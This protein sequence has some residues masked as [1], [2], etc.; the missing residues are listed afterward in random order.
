MLNA[1]SDFGGFFVKASVFLFKFRS[2]LPRGLNGI[3]S[4]D[5]TAAIIANLGHLQVEA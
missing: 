3:A 1:G 4:V 2:L 5:V